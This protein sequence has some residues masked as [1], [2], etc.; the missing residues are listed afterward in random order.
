MEE[1]IGKEA[2]K[3]VLRCLVVDDEPVTREGMVDFIA[4]VEF[5]EL[6]GDCSSALEAMEYVNK[7]ITDLIFLDINM[8]YLSG[9]D[10]LES[11]DNPPL[12]IFT[13]AYSE[14]ALEG[15]RLQVVDYLMKPIAFKRFYQAA[16]N[17]LQLFKLRNPVES[18]G[19]GQ[20][21][22]M[23]IRQ[24]DSFEKI[25]WPDILYIESMQ[26]YVK[27]HFREDKKVIHQTLSSLEE[28]LPKEQFFRIHKSFLINVAQID[29][30]MSGRVFVN[31]IELPLSRHRKEDLLNQVVYKNLISK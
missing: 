24:G 20:Q 6:V 3:I 29:S 13:T 25:Y 8:P 1:N 17:A 5:L 4:K 28:M 22:Y 26:N 21:E 23:Y 30:I 18:S 7:G 11:L 27:L 15:Y 9:M 14:Y 12:T 31:G 16:V 2:N 10:F 19:N